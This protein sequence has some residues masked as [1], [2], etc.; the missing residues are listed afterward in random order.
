MT[1]EVHWIG[2]SSQDDARYLMANTDLNFPQ[3]PS[4]DLK[5]GDHHDD[6]VG[7]EWKSFSW[8][9]LGAHSDEMCMTVH[10]LHIGPI[11]LD[12]KTL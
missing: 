10:M 1:K 7:G 5:W 2:K 8:S 12:P 3:L 4:S 11:V 9:Q 6:S